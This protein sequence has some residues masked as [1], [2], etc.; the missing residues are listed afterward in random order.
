VDNPAWI[1]TVFCALMRRR[2]IGSNRE[3]WQVI[4]SHRQPQGEVGSDEKA[5]IGSSIERWEAVRKHR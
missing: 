3:R 2:G 4:W 5:Y 1:T